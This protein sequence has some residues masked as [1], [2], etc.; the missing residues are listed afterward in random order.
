LVNTNAARGSG[1]HQDDSVTGDLVHNALPGGAREVAD[2]KGWSNHTFNAAESVRAV[3]ASWSGA[4]AA[5][6]NP[7]LCG[8]EYQFEDAVSSHIR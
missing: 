8:E 7:E 3:D 1:R 4:I 5:G 2:H 6:E